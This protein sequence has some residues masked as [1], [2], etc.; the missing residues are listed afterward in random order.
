MKLAILGS[1]KGT[2]LQAIIDA[3]KEGTLDA[4]IAVVI[5]NKQD[6][7]ILERAK[8]HNIPTLFIDQKNKTRE[9]FDQDILTAL[10][11]Y[12][13]DLILLIGY[14]RI[15]SPLFV[16]AYKDRILNVHPSL[17]PAFA[18]G[19]DMNVH[20]AVVESGVKETG[21]TVH[22]VDE[23]VDTGKILVQKKCAVDPNDTAET[24]KEKVQK[25]E[26]EAFVEAIKQFIL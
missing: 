14:M 2:D 18:G 11:Q 10:E 26:G 17:L 20:Q 9:Q 25:L 4:E 19:M 16:R 15:L 5:S 1:T 24:L 23:G 8:N 7:Y 13:P 21:C 22:L 3:I 6:A 12:K